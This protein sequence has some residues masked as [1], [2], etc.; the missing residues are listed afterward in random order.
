MF[1]IVKLFINTSEFVPSATPAALY[2]VKVYVVSSYS[3]I[4]IYLPLPILSSTYTPFSFVVASNTFPSVVFT[5]LF[6]STFSNLTLIPLR[7]RSLSSLFPFAF[8]SNHA[9]PVIVLFPCAISL[10]ST[11][12]SPSKLPSLAAIIWLISEVVA[13]LSPYTSAYAILVIASACVLPSE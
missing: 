9:S 8:S 1:S 2:F 4:A 7:A 6:V 3:N 10:S 5:K 12:L 13:T 11:L